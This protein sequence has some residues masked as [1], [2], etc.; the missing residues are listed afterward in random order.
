MKYIKSFN[1]SLDLGEE[2]EEKN[3]IKELIKSKP[4]VVIDMINSGELDPSSYNN[5]IL[6]VS[7]KER[8][9]NIVDLVLQKIK[10]TPKQN[11]AMIG[12]CYEHSNSDAVDLIM[13]YQNVSNTDI[14]NAIKWVSASMRI[15][16]IQK[17]YDIEDLK[18]RIK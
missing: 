9:D 17:E 14:E 8:K 4:N 13:K 5:I 7:I 6:R 1:E 2:Y 3:K 11:A 10:L 12:H 16:D 18:M 15:K